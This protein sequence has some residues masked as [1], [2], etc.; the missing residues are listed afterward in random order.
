MRPPP[1][2][3]QVLT[4]RRKTVKGLRPLAINQASAAGSGSAVY[5]DL[6]KHMKDLGSEDLGQEDRREGAGRI[7]RGAPP[8]LEPRGLPGLPAKARGSARDRGVRL[9][10]LPADLPAEGGDP[11]AGEINRL[12]TPCREPA[13]SHSRW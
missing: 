6:G 9:A 12:A 10:N 13:T 7:D 1:D 5:K 4:T 8:R 3:H 2:F 11:E